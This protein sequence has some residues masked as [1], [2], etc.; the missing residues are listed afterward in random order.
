MPNLSSAYI[1]KPSIAHDGDR[2]TERGTTTVIRTMTDNKYTTFSTETDV[3]I[4]TSDAD[5]NATRIDTL[6]L[7]LKNVDSYSFTPTGGSGSGFSNRAIPTEYTTR[8]GRTQSAIVNGFQH[9]IYFLPT[10]VTATEVRLQFTGS[11]IEVY[12]VML[13]ET[14]VEIPDGEFVE[15][16]PRKVDRAGRIHELP[17]GDVDRGSVLGAE[18]WKWEIDYRLKVTRRTSQT[19]VASVLRLLAENTDIV[20]MQEPARYP[21]RWYPASQILLSKPTP[22]RTRQ[23]QDGYTVPFEVAEQ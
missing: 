5:G 3:D 15:V 22:L 12:A 9:E 21:S 14:V 18:R 20:F 6:A 7:K 2:V 10:H 19:S 23:K 8:D 4:D 13:L 1:F 17:N 11:N 16:S